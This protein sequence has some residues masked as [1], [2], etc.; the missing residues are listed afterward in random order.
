MSDN[1]ITDEMVER[2]AIFLQ[3]EWAGP[4][5]AH[6]VDYLPPTMGPGPERDRAIAALQAADQRAAAEAR[7][8][9]R[10]ALR[11]TLGRT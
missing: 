1:P 4:Y 7:R 5:M 11:V 6:V 8:V 9:A 2:L 3:A 10:A